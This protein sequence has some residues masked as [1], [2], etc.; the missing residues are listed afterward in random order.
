MTVLEQQ[1]PGKGSAVGYFLT[2]HNEEGL[3]EPGE[4]G[5]I[6]DE[7]LTW[8]EAAEAAIYY[9]KENNICLSYLAERGA[10]RKGVNGQPFYFPLEAKKVIALA[11]LNQVQSN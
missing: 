6:A 10:I 11:L 3:N 5:M 4:T 7:T 9:C 2:F 8:G 1:V